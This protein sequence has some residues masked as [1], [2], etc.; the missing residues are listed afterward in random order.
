MP[1][2]ERVRRQVD[3][4]KT[5]GFMEYERQTG[6]EVPPKERI[7]NWKEF[8]LPLREEEQRRQGARCMDCGVPLLPVRHDDGAAW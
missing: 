8:H 5:T 3:M 1:I 6:R 2:L 7:K 4:G